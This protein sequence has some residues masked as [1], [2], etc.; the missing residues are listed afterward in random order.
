[1]FVVHGPIILGVLRPLPP[2]KF[3]DAHNVRYSV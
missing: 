3:G 2:R 1:V